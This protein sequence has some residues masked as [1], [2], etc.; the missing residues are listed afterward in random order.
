[1]TESRSPRLNPRAAR[2][3]AKSRTCAWY[4]AHVWDCQMPRSFSRMAVLRARSRALRC[5]RRGSVV[6]S[7][8]AVLHGAPLRVAEV[9]LDDERVGPHLVRTALGDLLAHVEHGHAVGDVHDHAH[10]VLDEDD[11]G[12]PLLVHV[13]DRSEEHTFE[14]QSPCNLV[15]RLLLEK[16]K[17]KIRY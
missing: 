5:S 12:A 14:L 16:K 11:G 3:S 15:C 2:P 9:G 17:K 8:T 6:R 7:A 1:M 13:E 4:S 10:V